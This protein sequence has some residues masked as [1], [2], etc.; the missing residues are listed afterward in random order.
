MST[1]TSLKQR[2]KFEQKQSEQMDDVELLILL[3]LMKK[4]FEERGVPYHLCREDY[5]RN[6]A[7]QSMNAYCSVLWY[8][9]VCCPF[10]SSFRLN[11]AVETLYLISLSF[12]NSNVHLL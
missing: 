8:A 3:R 5:K 4:G 12:P 1:A 7:G 11:C 2:E 10:P 6:K 9:F